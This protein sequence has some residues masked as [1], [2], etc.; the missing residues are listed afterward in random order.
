M[1]HPLIP[2]FLQRLDDKVGYFFPGKQHA[3]K[4]EGDGASGN[5]DSQR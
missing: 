3:A 2:S 5:R 1:A 4:D